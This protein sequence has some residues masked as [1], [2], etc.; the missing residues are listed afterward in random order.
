MN[1]IKIKSSQFQFYII[2]IKIE[3]NIF[4]NYLNKIYSNIHNVNNVNNVN[5]NIRIKYIDSI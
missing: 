2:C 3:N 1:N 5:A 4:Y